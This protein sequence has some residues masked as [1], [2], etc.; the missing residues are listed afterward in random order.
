MSKKPKMERQLSLKSKGK[1]NNI[2]PTENLFR[3]T[4]YNSSD[5]KKPIIKFIYDDTNKQDYL[6]FLK[7]QEQ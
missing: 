3:T 7:H 1:S 4:S 2:D 5:N 6:K